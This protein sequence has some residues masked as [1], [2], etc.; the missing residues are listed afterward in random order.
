[1]LSLSTG[2]ARAADVTLELSCPSCE[3]YNA[4]TVFV[5]TIGRSGQVLGT[6]GPAQK[7]P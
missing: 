1:L 7:G 6:F 4:C 3:D 5:Q 2:Q